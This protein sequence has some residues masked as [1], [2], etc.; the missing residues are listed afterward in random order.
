MAKLSLSMKRG[1]TEKHGQSSTH[2]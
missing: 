2:S 1:H